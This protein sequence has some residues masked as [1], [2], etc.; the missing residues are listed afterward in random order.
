MDLRMTFNE[1]ELNYDRFRPTYL[2]ELFEQ[3]L[4]A[5]GRPGKALEIGIGTGQ[6]TQSFLDAG[7]RLTAI[8]IGSRMIDFCRQKFAGTPHFQ[9]V[10]ADFESFDPG[11]S[12]DLIY[13]ATAF[14]WIPEQTGYP[15]AKAL[16]RPGGTLALFWNHPYVNR[17]DDPLHREI[18]RIYQK[19]QPGPAPAE[20]SPKDCHPILARLER[21]GFDNIRS[22][23]FHGV[24]TLEARE[25]IALMNTY[26]C[27]RAMPADRKRGLEQEI[28]QA[29]DHSGG[30]L[31]IYDTIDLYLAQRPQNG[32]QGEFIE[33]G[34]PHHG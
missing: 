24:R 31:K 20:F 5:A 16:L 18:S 10:C 15:K 14:H 32:A 12:Y 30:T 1:D 34:V 29:I 21:Y 13:S 11:E 27:H 8:D 25:Y 4:N 17:D 9:A 2:P 6:A 33:K 3:I 26:S 22:T 19:Y 7:Y 28:A 23:L